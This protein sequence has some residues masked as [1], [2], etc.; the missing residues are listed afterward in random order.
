M[1]KSKNPGDGAGYPEVAV[2]PPSWVTVGKF[3]NLPEAAFSSL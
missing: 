2:P 3:P 1:I